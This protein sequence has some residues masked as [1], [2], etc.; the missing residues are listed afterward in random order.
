MSISLLPIILFPEVPLG[1]L[2]SLGVSHSSLLEL[3]TK[4]LIQLQLSKMRL[5]FMPLWM[6]PKR[7]ILPSSFGTTPLQDQTVLPLVHAPYLHALFAFAPAMWIPETIPL[8]HYRQSL[9]TFSRTSSGRESRPNHG[10]VRDPHRR[11]QLCAPHTSLRGLS[12][13]WAH[14]IFIMWALDFLL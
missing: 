3:S 12:R 9:L 10:F 2:L 5:P 7:S 11:R 13:Y 14:N 4:G 1:R 8:N 6:L